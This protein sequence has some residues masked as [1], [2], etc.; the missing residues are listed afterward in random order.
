MS[1]G[2]LAVQ[3]DLLTSYHPA[4]GFSS[5]QPHPAR[6]SITTNAGHGDCTAVISTQQSWTCMRISTIQ[7]GYSL[8]TTPDP[9]RV[10]P[11]ANDGGQQTRVGGRGGERRR[12]AGFSGAGGTAP[13]WLGGFA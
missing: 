9:W 3:C 4:T 6:I 13:G 2:C 5:C 7:L 11:S 1:L 10:A 8:P 12:G